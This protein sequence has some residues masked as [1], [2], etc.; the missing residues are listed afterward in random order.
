[1]NS[2][3]LEFAA[4]VLSDDDDDEYCATTLQFCVSHLSQ[5]ILAPLHGLHG[6][7]RVRLHGEAGGHL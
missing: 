2:L 3:T 7:I 5:K 4:Y 1:M 6:F